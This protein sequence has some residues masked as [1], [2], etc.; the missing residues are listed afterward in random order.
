MIFHSC[1]KGEMMERKN[2]KNPVREGFTLVEL[3]VVIAI[4]G[5][6]AAII[7]PSLMSASCRAKAGATQSKIENIQTALEM[8]KN[9]KGRFP[10]ETEEAGSETMVAALSK[11]R[12]R[13]SV[14]F[15]FDDKFL[16]TVDGNEK[17]FT[18][19]G[20]QHD[21]FEIH[22]ALPRGQHF[23]DRWKYQGSNPPNSE[24]NEFQVNLWT[25]GCDFSPENSDRSTMYQINNFG[26]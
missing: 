16:R 26:N 15:Q 10:P 14:Y 11:P 2:R 5:I 1:R 17:L 7:I 20:R 6:L 21:A 12:S 4:I 8:Y 9:D 18:P 25:A 24:L 3:L 19:L 23:E 13:D 22:Y